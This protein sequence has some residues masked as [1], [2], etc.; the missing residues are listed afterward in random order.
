MRMKSCGS[1][2][3]LWFQKVLTKWIR[4]QPGVQQTFCKLRLRLS[5]SRIVLGSMTLEEESTGSGIENRDFIDKCIEEDDPYLLTFAPVCVVRAETAAMISEQRREWSS[6][7]CR[8]LEE[9]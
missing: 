2:L 3:L 6:G 7:C 8:L 9:D 1:V 4:R 5:T